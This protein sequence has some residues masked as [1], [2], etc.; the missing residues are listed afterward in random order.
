VARS[1][2]VVFSP[3]LARAP[4][5]WVSLVRWLR[6]ELMVFSLSVAPPAAL[7]SVAGVG[8]AVALA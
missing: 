4:V 8:D 6:S 3:I 1:W 7:L 5:F 2:L